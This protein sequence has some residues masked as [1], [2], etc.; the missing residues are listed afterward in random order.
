M[1]GQC[2]SCGVP[3]KASDDKLGKQV[4]CNQCAHQFVLEPP[5]ADD[6][7]ISK[8]ARQIADM[9]SAPGVTVNPAAAPNAA[10]SEHREYR[11]VVIGSIIACVLCG[12][13]GLAIGLNIHPPD[14]YELRQGYEAGLDAG[15]KAGVKDGRA[16]QREIDQARIDQAKRETARA[17]TTI[18][19]LKRTADNTV[20]ARLA[21]Q[22]QSARL[23]DAQELERRTRNI[24]E[25]CKVE[26]DR[27]E[28]AA[29]RRGQ[30]DLREK[31]EAERDAAIAAARDEY[32]AALEQRRQQIEADAYHR[33][34]MEGGYEAGYQK[35]LEMGIE[36]GRREGD[37]ACELRVTTATQHGKK[38]GYDEGFKA[39]E[40]DGFK[41]GKAEGRRI[42]R[43][44]GYEKGDYNGYRR[45]YED[46]YKAA[47]GRRP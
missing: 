47:G 39:G 33:G 45:G 7:R 8:A 34:Q 35:G 31:L 4:R 25:R 44:E 20:A 1:I 9:T 37:D 42:G 14:Q 10:V 41:R 24:N 2:P 17:Q 19:K 46:G 32:R 11:L 13:V 6:S 22:L 23:T 5:A 29:H 21:E 27:A 38:F 12:G 36:R 16:E 28:Y 40:I 30:D 18:S 15:Y 43:K 3:F 26:I